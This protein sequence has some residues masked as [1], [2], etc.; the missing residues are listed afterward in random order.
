MSSLPYLGLMRWRAS[1]YPLAPR[2]PSKTS[3]NPAVGPWLAGEPPALSNWRLPAHGEC[4]SLPRWILT[5]PSSTPA[6]VKEYWSGMLASTS[7]ILIILCSVCFQTNTVVCQWPKYLSF[8]FERRWL[9]M[10]YF[11]FFLVWH[12][13]TTGLPQINLFTHGFVVRVL[14]VCVRVFVCERE[15]AC[16]HNQCRLIPA[17]TG[18]CRRYLRV[19]W[20]LEKVCVRIRLSR[21]V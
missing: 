14:Q 5:P 11:L 7:F 10:P 16:Q 8:F 1:L 6:C 4:W 13:S 9:N 20:Q 18:P 12:S 2:E 17:L 19:Q 21:R 3:V 15:C